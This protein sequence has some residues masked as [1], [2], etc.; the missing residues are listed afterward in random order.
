ML[1]KTLLA[2]QTGWHKAPFIPVVNH[3]FSTYEVTV[4][5]FGNHQYSAPEGEHDYV[6][7][8]AMLALSEAYYAEKND[9]A[10]ELLE[11]HFTDGPTNEEIMEAYSED[12]EFFTEQDDE[13]DFTED[14]DEM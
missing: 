11:K 10:F 1:T 4:S 9:Q 7:S 14:L 6:V 2:I 13:E 3:E 5:K 8:A 12:D